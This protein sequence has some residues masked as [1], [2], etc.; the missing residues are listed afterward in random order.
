MNTINVGSRPSPS[1]SASSLSV[2]AKKQG[3]DGNQ[4]IVS[5]DINGRHLWK[6]RRNK[7]YRSKSKTKSKTKSKSM[8]KKKLRAKSMSRSKA[9]TK[10]KTKAKTKSK[11][12]AKT[13]S[14]QRKGPEASATLYK[15]GTKKQGNDGNRWIVSEASNG[16]KRWKLYKKI[17]I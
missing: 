15:V 13:K 10:S 9:K 8:V 6:M 2:G 14:K 11:T 16:V 3:N 7:I 5:K 17:D 4:W 1:I 12:K